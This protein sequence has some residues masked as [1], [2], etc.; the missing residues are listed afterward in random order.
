MSTLLTSLYSQQPHSYTRSFSL[1]FRMI[2][3]KLAVPASRCSLTRKPYS[4]M[5]NTSRYRIQEVL[6]VIELG[7]TTQLLLGNLLWACS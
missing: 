6:W 1:A 4:H 7:V 2:I 5:G 3:G